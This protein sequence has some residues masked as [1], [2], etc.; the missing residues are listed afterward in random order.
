MGLRKGD[1][2]IVSWIVPDGIC[3]YCASGKENY[4]PAAAGRM[5]GLVGLNGGHAEYLTVP[6]I[7]VIPWREVSMFT[8]HRQ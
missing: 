2:V 1:P 5:P 4:C 3:K 7:A 8:T 6:E